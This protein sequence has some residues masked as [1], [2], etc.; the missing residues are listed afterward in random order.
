M[1]TATP[2]FQRHLRGLLSPSSV[3]QYERIVGLFAAFLA[4]QRDGKAVAFEEVTRAEVA[5]FLG[6]R[7]SRSGGPSKSTW[8]QRL[9]AL[10]MLYGYLVLQESLE[11]KVNPALNFKF[12]TI[13]KRE[14][15][16]LTFEELFRMMEVLESNTSPTRS[17]N[18][19]IFLT[20][21][22]CGVRVSELLSIDVGQLHYGTKLIY[23]VLRKRGRRQSQEVNDV[24]LAALR[25]CCIDRHL[26]GCHPEESAL[27][28]SRRGR[29]L[30]VRSVQELIK[31][32]AEAAGIGRRVSPHMLRHSY[33]S[34]LNELG[35]SIRTIRDQLAH[36]KITTTEGYVHTIPNSSHQRPNDILETA[37]KEHRL[38]YQ[39]QDSKP[40]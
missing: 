11:E 35:V 17:R 38:L 13:T 26:L 33:A 30:S 39:M 15:V 22:H 36:D 40:P 16:P 28:V 18:L 21:F 14:V 10:R 12:K 25:E 3:R 32:T 5:H 2:D 1:K 37:W 23:K 19:A 7:R 8:N 20:L 24:V 31:T 29:R 34:H 9:A 6:E 4:E 27:F